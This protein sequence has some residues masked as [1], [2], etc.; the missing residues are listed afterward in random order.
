MRNGVIPYLRDLHTSKKEGIHEG[1]VDRFAG[2]LLLRLSLYLVLTIVSLES[3][4]LLASHGY[5]SVLFR[6]NGPLEWIH[7]LLPAASALILA[8]IAKK[9]SD[10]GNILKMVSIIMI[11]LA[12][13]EL[14]YFLDLY[15][16]IGAYRPV[17]AFAIGYFF[18][19]IWKNRLLLHG[20]SRSYM[21]T[22]SFYFIACGLLLVI[23]F[24]QIIGQK[25]LWM[26]VMG[27]GFMRIVKDAVEETSE[28]IGYL[29]LFFGSLEA[30]FTHRPTEAR[31]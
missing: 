30:F 27:E 31:P 4:V 15:L 1:L 5:A 11:V 26:T 18:Y 25:E 16:F 29:L 20:Q 7:F 2:F 28:T 23:V 14:D 6:E 9:H 22:S 13:R 12:V 19:L 24:A 21:K 8:T 3:L 17:I 10:E